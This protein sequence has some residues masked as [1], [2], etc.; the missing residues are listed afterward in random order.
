MSKIKKIVSKNLGIV[1]ENKY[2]YRKTI[3]SLYNYNNFNTSNLST[4]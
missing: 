3:L 1:R 4:L 2:E